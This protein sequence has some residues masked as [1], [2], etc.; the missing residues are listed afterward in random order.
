MQDRTVG[1]DAACMHHL[2]PV[3]VDKEKAGVT[4]RPSLWQ[5]T[6]LPFFMLLVGNAVA[7]E[8]T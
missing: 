2:L 3:D 4:S 8:D 7:N 5:L 6:C 1:V